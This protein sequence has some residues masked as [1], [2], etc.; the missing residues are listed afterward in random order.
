MADQEREFDVSVKV[1]PGG[2]T[3]SGTTRASSP[4]ELVEHTCDRFGIRFEEIKELVIESGTIKIKIIP[5]GIAIG[6]NS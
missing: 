4:G 2:H 1:K 6:A 3:M 5:S